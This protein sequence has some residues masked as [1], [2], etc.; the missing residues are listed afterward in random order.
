MYGP[1][2]FDMQSSLMLSEYV[3]HAVRNLK[4]TLPRPVT[5]LVTSDE[6]TGSRSSRK[7]IENE[8]KRSAYVLVMESP[9]LNGVIKTTRKRCGH[10]EVH[11]TGKAVH[12]GIELKKGLAPFRSWHTRFWLCM[13]S[14]IWMWEA[15]SMW[16]L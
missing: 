10:F 6:E 3:L 13:N 2:I 7:L 12:A 11:V 4:L 9:L 1:G 15:Q 8:A 5:I 14:R 16:V